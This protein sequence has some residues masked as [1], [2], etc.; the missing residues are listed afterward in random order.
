M[1]AA[2]Q[3]GCV[4]TP[5][6]LRPEEKWVPPHQDTLSYSERV[7]KVNKSPTIKRHDFKPQAAQSFAGHAQ[8]SESHPATQRGHLERSWERKGARLCRLVKYTPACL[9]VKSPYL[10][11][12]G[13]FTLIRI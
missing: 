3:Q 1:W 9:Y 13:L 12:P 10:I 11:H 4:D 5:Y 8:L 7:E 6:S 2:N